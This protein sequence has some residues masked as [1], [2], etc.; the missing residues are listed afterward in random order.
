M[1]SMPSIASLINNFKIHIGQGALE[2]PLLFLAEIAEMKSEKNE[3]K[4]N[5][6]IFIVK[7]VHFAPFLGEK[8]LNFY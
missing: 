2:C 4:E 7:K 5:T 8:L 1:R 6:F 3:K